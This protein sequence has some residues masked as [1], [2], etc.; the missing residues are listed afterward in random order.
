MKYQ[1]VVT[2]K[3]PGNLGPVEILRNRR[4]KGF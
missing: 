4:D 2:P 3:D 1:E